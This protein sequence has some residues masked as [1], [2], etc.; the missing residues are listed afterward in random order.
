MENEK[1][2][3]T[4]ETTTT[5]STEVEE[6]NVAKDVKE[7]KTFTQKELDEIVET[8]LAKARKGIPSKEELKQ[9]NDWKEKQKT[10]AEK[11]AEREKENQKIV[12]ERNNLKKENILL[13][14]GVKENDLDYVLFKISKQ[15]GD[16][17]ENLDE[18]LKKNPKFLSSYK[19]EEKRVDLGGNHKEKPENDNALARKIMGLN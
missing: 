9:F 17:E 16:F 11:Q 19:E 10:D 18:F 5:Q 12:E 2:P 3:E 4:V 6:K 14:K 8:R 15:E 13:R 7:E 1:N